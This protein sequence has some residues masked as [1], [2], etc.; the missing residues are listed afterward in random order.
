MYGTPWALVNLLK[1]ADRQCGSDLLLTHVMD[2][3][4]C[5]VVLRTAAQCRKA[6]MNLS[7]TDG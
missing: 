1:A 5:A 4:S 7:I 3:F 2:N 6:R